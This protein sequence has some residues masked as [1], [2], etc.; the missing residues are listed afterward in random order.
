MLLQTST[1]PLRDNSAGMNQASFAFEVTPARMMADAF[2]VPEDRVA[3]F[4]VGLQLTQAEACMPKAQLADALRS[5]L[6]DYLDKAASSYHTVQIMSMEVDLGEEQC[7]NGRRNLRKLLAAFSSASAALQMLIV[8]KA[9]TGAEF[10]EE[11]F[12]SM[13]GVTSVAQ[14]PRNSP[15]ITITTALACEQRGDCGMASP[16]DE[17][18]A[19]DNTA[20][21]A[22]VAGGV[23]G[24]VL[25]AG[26]VLVYMRSKRGEVTETAEAVQTINIEDLKSQLANEA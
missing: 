11:R 22:G 21:I 8:F 9:G 10:N 25:L 18:K 15:K 26:G 3:L 1:D 19:E 2:D 17:D 16:S 24:A 12:A 20:M 4:D 13:A 14:D 6:I 5:T 7:A 23:G